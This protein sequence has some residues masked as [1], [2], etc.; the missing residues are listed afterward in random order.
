WSPRSWSVVARRRSRRA[1]P[2]G[3][4]GWPRRGSSARWIWSWPSWTPRPRRRCPR[5][6]TASCAPGSWSGPVGLLPLDRPGRLARDVE[7]DP[8]DLA[9]LVDHARGDLLQEVVGQA[10]PVGGHR[11]VAGDGAD[12]DDVAI[13]A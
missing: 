9:Q 1:T 4:G 5:T 8:V 10:R 3:R 2:G 12:D 11:V 13:G 6:G 7:H